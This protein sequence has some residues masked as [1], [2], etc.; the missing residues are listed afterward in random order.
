MEI[1]ENENVVLIEKLPVGEHFIAGEKVLVKSCGRL[2]LHFV[3]A[4]TGHKIVREFDKKDFSYWYDEKQDMI[5]PVL[6]TTFT[7]D[8]FTP[9]LTSG[10]MNE[11]GK[12]MPAL[13]V[14]EKIYDGKRYVICQVDLRCENPI[15]KRFLRNILGIV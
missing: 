15:A 11:N 1:P 7:A 13:A 12:W 5:T 10:N 3:S 14:A 8:G 6:E 4:A 2:P 9:I